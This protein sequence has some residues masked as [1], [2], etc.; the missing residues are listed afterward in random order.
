M[1]F[2]RAAGLN[3]VRYSNIAAQ[4]VRKALKQELKEDAAKREISTIKFQKWEAGK[5][6]GTKQ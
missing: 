6:V 5:A 2:W 1:T 4:C 3:Y